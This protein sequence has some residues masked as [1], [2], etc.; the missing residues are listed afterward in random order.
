MSERTSQPLLRVRAFACVVWLCAAIPAAHAASYD[1]SIDLRAVDSNGR[2]SYLDGGLGKLRYDEKDSGLHL[3]RLRAAITQPLGEVFAAHAEVSSWGDDDK[4]PVDLTEAFVEYRPYPRAGFRSRVRLGAFYPPMSL[5]NRALGWETPYTITPSAISSWVGEELRTIGL[6][7]QEDWL[8]T[9]MGHSFDFQLTGALYE[10]NDPAGVMMAMHGFA[11]DDRQTTLF[12]RV[13]KPGAAAVPA[14]EPFHEIDHRPGFY[15]GGQARYLDRAV[16]NVLHYDNRA[17]PT[18]YDAKIDDF[19]WQTS[20]D[21]AALRV[22]TGNDWTVLLQWLRGDT[23]IHPKP[24][25]SFEWEFASRSAM[26]AKT[27]GRHMLTARYDTFKVETGEPSEGGNED[28]HA[29][30]AAYSFN[31][32]N[33]WR[34]M[35]EWLRVRSD[36]KARTEILGEP[37]LATETKIEISARYAISVP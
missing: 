12:G 7:V 22:E 13:G 9:R 35:L 33:S 17:D 20:F 3:G 19:A 8:G 37:S 21:A 11:F 15:V 31:P 5:E 24:R 28:G 14:R 27:I 23:Y 16:L 2:D 6:E 30:T 29:W 32:G 25:F 34:F 4:N 18:A 1:F 36:V 26:L 10:W